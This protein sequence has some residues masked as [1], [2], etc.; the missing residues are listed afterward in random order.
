[1]CVNNNSSSNINEAIETIL[2]FY[3]KISQ[4]QKAQNSYKRTKTKNAPKKHLRGKKSLIRLFA[5]CAFAWVSLC[6]LMLFVLLLRAK[7]FRKKK[8]LN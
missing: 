4:A 3:S 7:S 8:S 5:F 2:D 6:R 1:M